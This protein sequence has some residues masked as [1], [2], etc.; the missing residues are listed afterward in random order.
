MFLRFT[1]LLT[2][3]LMAAPFCGCCYASALPAA[4]AEACPA[5]HVDA[6]PSA[7]ASRS[8]DC[9][10]CTDT[11]SRQLSPE[12]A[13]APRPVLVVLQAWVRPHSEFWAPPA[14][15]TP[16][17]VHAPLEPPRSRAA[18]LYLRHCALLH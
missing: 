18:P 11:L 14:T 10:C 7:P 1:S 3:C 15:A 17:Q 8:S 2:A 12:P 9:P 13:A 5:C 6:E 4:E 16:P